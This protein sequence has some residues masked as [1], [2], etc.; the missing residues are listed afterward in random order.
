MNG[1]GTTFDLIIAQPR[2]K[3]KF[4]TQCNLS[5]VS[6]LPH[7]EIVLPNESVV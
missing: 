4:L 1:L 7:S 6:P 2:G 3:L 5:L